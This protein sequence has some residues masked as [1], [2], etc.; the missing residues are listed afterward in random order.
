MAQ[1]DG[2]SINS[3][4]GCL[5]V[6]GV[7]NIGSC[8][9]LYLA[10]CSELVKCDHNNLCYSPDHI[11]VYHPRYQSLPVCYPVPNY[12]QQLCPPISIMPNIP[13]NSTWAQ[14]GVTVAGRSE[15]DN[16]TN[17]L[18]NAGGLFVDDDETVVI[19]DSWN[20]RIIQWKKGYAH[21]QIVAGGNDK[22]IRLDQLNEPSDV[23]VDKETDSVIICDR[24]KL[25]VV[26]W[27]R[28]NGT[29]QGEILIDNIDSYGLTMD[30]QRYLYVS[31]YRKFEVRR[32]GLGDKNG[33]LV[34]GGNGGGIDLGQLKF[35]SAKEGIVVTGGHD[36]GN[37]S[38]QLSYPKGIFVDMLGTVYVA[39]NWSHR[40]MRWP[41][42]A[43]QGD[44]IAG[45][46]GY[47]L[48]ANQFAYPVGLSFDRNGNLYV[49][50]QFNR[51]VQR[52]SLV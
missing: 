52:F 15:G 40:V 6:V 10:E 46:N 38:T 42:G 45:G 16:S 48:E 50:D 36:A 44:V 51:R 31:D 22:G 43:K 28:H 20:H 49:V 25:R 21:G 41:S 34:A 2:C 13:A 7:I 14:N 47:G 39:D 30:D 9:Y 37:A 8:S 26:R 17:Q 3:G 11:C 33:I 19:A 35:P 18:W 5:Q 24:W 27:S 4:C 12:N 29:K 32:Y 23:L 1:Y